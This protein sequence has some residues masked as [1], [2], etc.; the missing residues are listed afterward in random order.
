MEAV[1]QLI[2]FLGARGMATEAA[3]VSREHVEA[4]VQHL[5]D[6]EAGHRLQ[7]VSSVVSI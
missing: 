5:L 4:Y 7:P 1:Q 3:A 2:G 6:H